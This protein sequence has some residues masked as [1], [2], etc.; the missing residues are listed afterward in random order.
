MTDAY[1]WISQNGIMSEQDYRYEARNKTCRYKPRS[2]AA[3]CTGFKELPSGSEDDLKR[4]VTLIGPISVGIHAMFDTLQFYSS[5][6]YFEPRCDP[7]SI[8][9][10]VVVVGYGTSDNGEDYWII[11]NSWGANWGGKR[12]VCV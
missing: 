11:K 4:A 9:H 5:G 1:T 7:L 10:A 6:V 2:K 12:S 8:N 3:S